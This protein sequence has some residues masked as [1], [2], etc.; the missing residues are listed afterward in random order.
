MSKFTRR[1]FLKNSSAFAAAGGLKPGR[2][3][4]AVTAGGGLDPRASEK[5]I[6]KL[7]QHF[8]N[9][10][11]DISPW[12]FVPEE[13]IKEAS[14]THS[15]GLATI[16]PGDKGKDIKAILKEPIRIDEYPLPWEFQL[17]MVQNFGAM[18]GVKPQSN[19]AIGLNVAVTFSDPST[20]PKDRTQMPPGTHT[21]QLLVV[22][23]SGMPQYSELPSPD[24]Y[25]V[26]G[27][28]DLH[29]NILGDWQIP[30]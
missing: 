12:M 8:N 6:R 14:T 29:P 25:L 23:L 15:P 11:A 5:D 2:N 27:R 21:L 28:G 10:G 30:F 19:Y 13:N 24:V 26:W 22:H 3:L 20:W 16:W 1:E 4:S 7:S 9:P 18:A 17:G